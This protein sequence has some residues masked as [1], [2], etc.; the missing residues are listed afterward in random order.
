MLNLRRS[1]VIAWA[2]PVL[3]GLVW[4]FLHW[5]YC[6][7]YERGKFD[8]NIACEERLGRVQAAYSKITNNQLKELE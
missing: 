5:I 7:G 2:L 3:I 6:L 8:A 1:I 4:W